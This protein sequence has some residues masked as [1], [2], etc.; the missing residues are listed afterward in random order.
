[1]RYR[2]L[3]AQYDASCKYIVAARAAAIE[4][5]QIAETVTSCSMWR[6]VPAPH[7]V[8]SPQKWGR[9]PVHVY[10][11]HFITGMARFFS[12]TVFKDSYR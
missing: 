6:A 9:A 8:R 10:G 2:A 3:A 11:C 12:R 4:V 5:L 1:L 7:L